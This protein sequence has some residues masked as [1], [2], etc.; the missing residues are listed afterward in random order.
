MRP[1]ICIYHGNCADGFTA[2]WAVWKRWPDVV[3][4]PG[5]YGEPPPDVTGKH[6]LMVD[7]SYKR[8][9]IDAMASKAASI[10]ILDHHKTAEANLA[11]FSV[12]LCGGAVLSAS[13]IEDML[14][15][16]AELERPAVLASFDMGR[17][18]AQIA[19][20]Y[21][22]TKIA[23][24]KI[25]DYVADRDL[26]KFDLPHSRAVAAWIFS[27]PYA[28]PTWDELARQI[29]SEQ[30][31]AGVVAQGEAIERK[32]HKDIRELLA[33]MRR[34]MVI[35]GQC[36]PVANL[37]YTMA[38]DA[39]GELAKETPFAACYFDSA[40]GQRVFSLRSRGTAGADVSAI[41][42]AYGGGGHKNAAGFQMPLGWEGDTPPR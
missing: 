13:D 35:G 10:V 26:W 40:D 39:A 25:V 30:H 17:S 14:Q 29:G 4:H 24:P 11:P 18:G 27:H 36:V 33:Q 7:F 2:A 38:S 37:P 15:D 42:A 19:W 8:P 9:V 23:R 3:F 28:F 32:H 34:T 31:F 12:G 21:C 22:F 6:V 16:M 41:A 1:D 20:D 5:V